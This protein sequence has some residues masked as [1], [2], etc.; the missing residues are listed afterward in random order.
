MEAFGQLCR[1]YETRLLRQALTLC[2]DEAVAEDLAQETLIEAWKSLHRFNRR[3]Q[4]FTWLCAI[5]IHRYRNLARRHAHLV[6]DYPGEEFGSEDNTFEP[7]CFPSP[8]DAV[9]QNE[10]AE[11]V[12]FC[13]NALPEKHREV[14]YLRFFV[15]ESLEEVA[16]ALNCSVG[17]VKSRLYYALERLRGMKLLVHHAVHNHHPAIV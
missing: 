11:L 8:F 7:T 5:L 6:R 17:T 15:D 4:F 1:F 14:V 3:C 16:A 10:T 9:T 12:R 13:M 2:G